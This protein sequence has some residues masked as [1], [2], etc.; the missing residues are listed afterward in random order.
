MENSRLVA[1]HE[2]RPLERVDSKSRKHRNGGTVKRGNAGLSAFPRL[3]ILN[4]HSRHKSFKNKYLRKHRNGGT[5]V[6]PSF[7]VL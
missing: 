1:H 2:G 5:L 4:S 3:L 7:S 6:F